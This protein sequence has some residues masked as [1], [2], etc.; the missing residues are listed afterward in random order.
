MNTVK[1]QQ[2]EF[3]GLVGNK[4]TPAASNSLLGNNDPHYAPGEQMARLARFAGR[5]IT[6]TVYTNLSCMTDF[7]F[8][9][10]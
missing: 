5:G 3:S 1:P 4:V 2:K 9:F 8:V 6:P 7:G 10:P